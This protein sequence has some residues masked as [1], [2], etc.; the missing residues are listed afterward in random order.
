MTLPDGPAQTPITADTVLRYHLCW[1]HRDLD[2]VIALYH[3]DIQYHDF[4]QNRVLGYVELR[5]Y[6]RA[7]LPMKPAK[8]SFTATASASMA[9]P[10]S[11]STRS[12]S[13][14]VTAWWRSSPARRSP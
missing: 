3:P 14:V 4:F 7:C 13:R 1:K 2:G 9:A 10:R 12:P 6:V 11:S 5:D 8:I